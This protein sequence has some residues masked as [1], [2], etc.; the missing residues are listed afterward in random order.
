MP[1]LTSAI[2]GLAGVAKS[3]AL[4]EAERLLAP[5]GG[6]FSKLEEAV[7]GLNFNK[8]PSQQLRKT[9]EGRQVSPLEYDNVLGQMEGTVNKEEVMGMIGKNKTELKDVVLGEPRITE[10]VNMSPDRAYGLYKEG[11]ISADDYAQAEKTGF[12]EKSIKRPVHYEQYSE[13]GYIPGSYRE[14]FV[15]APP[16]E[17]PDNNLLQE[18]Q[19]EW[20]DGH[21]P[22]SDIRNP[23][24]RLRTNDREVNGKKILFVEEMQGPSSSEQSKMPEFLRKR[25]YDIGVKKALMLAKEGGY[26]GVAWTTGEMQVNRYPQIREFVDSIKYGS[27]Q[28]GKY[29]DIKFKDGLT[30]PSMYVNK[31]G[32]VTDSNRLDWQGKHLAQILPKETVEKILT[33]AKGTISG[34]DITIGGEGLKYLYDKQ[35]PSLFKK[36]GK[37]GVESITLPGT[38]QTVL[39]AE[40]IA[41][42]DS[43]ERRRILEGKDSDVHYIPITKKTPSRH[44]VYSMIPPTLAGMTA[45]YRTGEGN[46]Q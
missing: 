29:V 16:K 4:K 12:I 28:Q 30:L 42:F 46:A 24:V 31:E 25:I 10:K 43:P 38:K 1:L 40:D 35:L 8:M 18:G 36:Y 41:R 33:R 15:T 44:P 19:T 37:E 22:Y 20:R 6:F 17:A 27:N 39:S 9:M 7:T 14:R 45:M 5:K 11:M 13:P 34:E 26:D 21:G 23:V 2:R 32:I 3:D